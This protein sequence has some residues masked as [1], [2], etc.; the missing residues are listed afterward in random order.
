M[1]DSYI[2]KHF[3][4]L[5]LNKFPY[6]NWMSIKK[7]LK[8]YIYKVRGCNILYISECLLNY[9]ISLL[10]YW[11]DVMHAHKNLYTNKCIYGVTRNKG[12]PPSSSSSSPPPFSSSHIYAIC[13]SHT[14]NINWCHSWPK[15]A[16][17][18][19]T[20][21]L[22]ARVTGRRTQSMCVVYVHDPSYRLFN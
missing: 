7:S 17:N 14:Q 10:S 20:H 3:Y 15:R 2:E 8:T 9:H 11:Y 22:F 16:Y 1:N 12:V 4:L 5:I 21:N 13:S 6:G 19:S 18:M